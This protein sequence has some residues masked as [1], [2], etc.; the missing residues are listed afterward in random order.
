MTIKLPRGKKRKKKKKVN[1]MKK[2][3]E[4][5]KKQARGQHQN[6]MIV[7]KGDCLYR[8]IISY[9]RNTFLLLQLNLHVCVA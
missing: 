7:N 6:Q 5:K 1:S 3:K 2:R 4:K 9:K 8:I